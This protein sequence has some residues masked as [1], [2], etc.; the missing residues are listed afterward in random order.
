MVQYLTWGPIHCQLLIQHHFEE[1][2]YPIG[3]LQM[4]MI[5]RWRWALFT[6]KSGIGRMHEHKYASQLVARVSRID[7]WIYPEILGTSVL[8]KKESYTNPISRWIKDIVYK[9]INL[10]FVCPRQIHAYACWSR[11]DWHFV[12]NTKFA[13]SS[14]GVQSFNLHLAVEMNNLQSLIIL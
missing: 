4:S 11:K 5:H 10:A 1:H 8:T 12:P 2:L 13:V 9:W 3:L 14:A 7:M 6:P